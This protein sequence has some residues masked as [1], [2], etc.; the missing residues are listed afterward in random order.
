MPLV[1]EVLTIT[2]RPCCG[3]ARPGGLTYRAAE[4]DWGDA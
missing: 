1:F 3:T 4:E 2:E